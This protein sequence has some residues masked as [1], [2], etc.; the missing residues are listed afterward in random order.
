MLLV[1]IY[2]FQTLHAAHITTVQDQE[3]LSQFDEKFVEIK[4]KAYASDESVDNKDQ[5][6]VQKPAVTDSPLESVSSSLER[7]E[8]SPVPEELTVD[9]MKI[10]LGPSPSDFL[11]EQDET[12]DATEEKVKV[13]H[14]MF[15]QESKDS[16]FDDDKGDEIKIGQLR[17]F[18]RVVSKESSSEHKSTKISTSVE[19]KTISKEYVDGEEPKIVMEEKVF[20]TEDTDSYSKSSDSKNELTLTT[21]ETIKEDF[22]LQADGTEIKRESKELVATI[23]EDSQNSTDETS[24]KSLKKSEEVKETIYPFKK[25]VDGEKKDQLVDTIILKEETLETVLHTHT[26]E[27][28]HKIDETHL[29][30]ERLLEGDDEKIIAGSEKYTGE[31]RQTITEN[32]NENVE[33]TEKQIKEKDITESLFEIRYEP[34]EMPIIE[35]V[36]ERHEHQS[37]E[38]ADTKIFQSDVSVTETVTFSIDKNEKEGQEIEKEKVEKHDRSQRDSGLFEEP[39]SD[40]S[41]SDEPQNAEQLET[42]AFDNMAF[43]DE[44]IVRPKEISKS[45][46]YMADI[47]LEK[48]GDISPEDL[49]ERLTR[50]DFAEELK[51]EM[52]SSDIYQRDDDKTLSLSGTDYIDKK[53]QLIATP[54]EVD[55]IPIDETDRYIASGTMSSTAVGPELQGAVG[56]AVLANVPENQQDLQ[57]LESSSSDSSDEGQVFDKVSGKYVHWEIQHQYS[58]QFS[59]SYSDQGNKELGKSDSSKSLDMGEFYR[60]PESESSAEKKDS[61]LQESENG[62][63]AEI[64]PSTKKKGQ[65][66][67][68]SLS[69]DHTEYFDRDFE[70]PIH[71][72]DIKMTEEWEKVGD[73]KCSSE[74]E[75][76]EPHDKITEAYQQAV[77]ASII[78]SRIQ[79]DQERQKYLKELEAISKETRD[80]DMYS[81]SSISSTEIEFQDEDVEEEEFEEDEELNI[82]V[83]TVSQAVQTHDSQPLSVVSRESRLAHEELLK[84]T[85]DEKDRSIS[86]SIDSEELSTTYESQ[87]ELQEELDV[88][89]LSRK[90]P[91]TVQVQGKPLTETQ[92]KDKEIVDDERL[93]PIDENGDDIEGGESKSDKRVTFQTDPQHLCSVS[94]E[95]L[96]KTS[97]SSSEIEP[98]LLAASYD[99]ESGR[100][101]HVVTTYDLSPD[102]VEKQFL[103]VVQPPKT[104]LSSP[105]DDVFEADLTLGDNNDTVIEQTP[106]DGDVE[107]LPKD[108]YDDNGV[109]PQSLDTA[110]A[111]T[112]ALPS[113][114]APSPFETSHIEDHA[115]SDL[116][117]AA[118]KMKELKGQDSTDKPESEL[119]LDLKSEEIQEVKETESTGSASPFEI[120]SPSDLEGYQDYVEKQVEFEEKMF[121]SSTS[122]ASASSYAEV[123]VEDYE[124][125]K[126]TDVPAMLSPDK[127]ANE[128]SFEHSSLVSSETSEKSIGSS[129]EMPQVENICASQQLD[130]PMQF[131]SQVFIE[132]E[133]LPNGPTEVDY[134]PEIDLDFP[135]QDSQVEEICEPVDAIVPDTSVSTFQTSQMTGSQVTPVSSHV[136]VSSSTPQTGM[137]ES[138]IEELPPQSN[139]DVLIVSDQTLYGLEMPSDEAASMTTSHVECE[140]LNVSGYTS[141]SVQDD[142]SAQ[143]DSR[144]VFSQTVGLD[145]TDEDLSERPSESLQDLPTSPV[146]EESHDTIGA[147]TLM[148]QEA[149]AIVETSKTADQYTEKAQEE[150]KEE[151]YVL[152]VEQGPTS[153]DQEK[154]YSYKDFQT[155]DEDIGKENTEIVPEQEKVPS[156][157]KGYEV[158]LQEIDD[159]DLERRTPETF[160][161]DEPDDELMELKETPDNDIDSKTEESERE[162]I[163]STEER[164]QFEL[165]ADSCDLDRPLTPT[166]VD[167]NQGF[168]EETFTPDEARRLDETVA[169][170][171]ELEMQQIETK[172]RLLEKT[173]CDFVENVL[174]EVKVKVRFKTA[175]DIDDDVALVQSPLSENGGDMTDFADDLPFDEAEEL[176]E[177]NSEKDENTE[178]TDSVTPQKKDFEE[179]GLLEQNNILFYQSNKSEEQLYA[180]SAGTVE[181]RYHPPKKDLVDSGKICRP[182]EADIDDEPEINKSETDGLTC[183]NISQVNDS[184]EFKHSLQGASSD[185]LIQTSSSSERTTEVTSSVLS[186]VTTRTEVQT[187][188]TSSELHT[189]SVSDR[190]LGK[191]SDS[192]SFSVCS[193]IGETGQWFSISK[194]SSEQ[195]SEQELKSERTV[196]STTIAMPSERVSEFQPDNRSTLKF[197]KVTSVSTSIPIRK[198]LSVGSADSLDDEKSTEG[199]KSSEIEDLGDT[200]SVDSFTTVVAAD[201]EEKDDDEDRMADFASLTSSVHSDI[202]G[203]GVGDDDDNLNE[204]DPLEE[205]MAWAKDKK[206]KDSFQISEDIEEE[207]ILEDKDRDEEM[208]PWNKDSANVIGIMPHPWRKDEED[209]DSVGGSDRYDYVD[210][211]ALSVITELSD[212][213]RFEIINKEEIE[214]ESTGS[215]TGTGSDS[216]HYSSPDFPPPS[217]MSNLKFFNKSAERDDISVSSS[218]LEFERLER[219]I[220]QSRSSGSIENGSKDSFG[221]SLDETKFLSKSLEKDDVSISSSLADFERLEREVAQ[222]SS[223]S[224]IEKIFSPAIVSPPETGKSSE[225]SS[226]SGSMTSLA[227]FERLEKEMIGDESR[228]STCSIESSFSHVS[229]TSITSS[230]ASLNEFERLEQEFTIAE[231][232]EKE[233]QKIVSILEAGS[234][235]PNQYTSEPELSHS[236]S[237]A[238]TL[239]IKVTKPSKDDDMDKDSVEGREDIDED[240][241]SENKKKTRGDA[242]DDTDSLDGDRSEMTSS[243]TSAILK[244]ESATKIGTDYDIDSLHDSTHSSDGAMKI[245]SDSLGEKLGMSKPE[246]DKFDTDSLTD[247]EGVIEKS[248]EANQAAMEKSSDSLELK[249]SVM[250]KS[251]DSLELSDKDQEKVETDSLQ[252]AEDAM[253]A[254]VDSLESYQIVAKHN[255]MEVS[256]DSAGTGGWSSASSMF[257]RSSIDTMRSADKEE[258]VETG[259]GQ[260]PDEMAASMESW[261]EYEGEEETDNFYIISKY[262]SSLKEAAEMS[263]G[264]KTE[265][266]EYTH[267]YY[268]FEGNVAADNIQ[269]MMT[270]PDWDTSFGRSDS[271]KSPYLAKTPYEEKKKIYTMTEWEAMKKAKKLQMEEEER[272]KEH[273]EKLEQEETATSPTEHAEMS[274]STSDEQSDK[275]TSIIE[276]KKKETEVPM[277]LSTDSINVMEKTLTSSH[278]EEETDSIGSKTFSET[279]TCDSRTAYSKTSSSRIEM[280]KTQTT[281]TK[282]K[283]DSKTMK[284]ISFVV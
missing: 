139:Q 235:L 216:R 49:K 59:D 15:T 260:I 229:I 146:T 138:V 284:G 239:E 75:T 81:S 262:Q 184:S 133:K 267:P 5:I 171:R 85:F 153:E 121:Q 275:S 111:G 54:L 264:S 106:T 150:L 69:E 155:V 77:I 204:K 72:Y 269:Y 27:G 113:P 187:T 254:S 68:F 240:S 78:E 119:S 159:M 62:A 276:E 65:R 127:S 169:L 270:G 179:S 183:S 182:E 57:D 86:P 253:Q 28:K 31:H 90:Y 194:M 232:L 35:P 55:D 166:P 122:Q 214:S 71:S 123:C 16:L 89:A 246:N 132:D 191:S 112:S 223:D 4:E 101:S 79:T 109:Q 217:P 242:V 241:L 125:E 174:E 157:L 92:D 82:N 163:S 198:S 46:T 98:T 76:A 105:E 30:S 66:V 91:V 96:V 228:K 154:S 212:E 213:D 141:T 38:M 43:N 274:E 131:A 143:V 176:P 249:E 202:M 21:T 265:K 190:F 162:A 39:F 108:S 280:T 210:R 164:G 17:Q 219:E 61:V 230:Q 32:L 221:G 84:E 247:Q 74:S 243:I 114:P 100:V 135:G 23:N 33:A 25:D 73:E 152:K 224:S 22:E 200:S 107:L 87:I 83:T 185:V 233:A 95:D 88:S 209:S 250:E 11:F 102:A 225:K 118:I 170:S 64:S 203:G 63:D 158:T 283:S 238:T 236:E 231:E 124:Q 116:A 165:K 173:A 50:F 2:S 222:G 257:S 56:P 268:D 137:T 14:G 255:V 126:S 26:D 234:L 218:L 140:S 29:S 52:E 53:D 142:T 128:S 12:E 206:V 149:D 42:M 178:I 195:V 147:E 24:A 193:D 196:K 48:E 237:L 129:F 167:K 3:K 47:E 272:E 93:S 251:T 20:S 279:K 104:I 58:R 277:E 7:E 168:F 252:G 94:S 201:E 60:R 8:I 80:S 148:E 110:S 99:L 120:M 248:Q 188:V 97:T 136:T 215:G 45:V 256:M 197:E 273:K 186:S 130:E 266:S 278:I 145:R 172:N 258:H 226:V 282:V 6:E 211:T 117:S 41:D 103:P 67:R 189:V 220:N 40:G 208:F 51:E 18:E 34:G 156:S 151:D 144:E 134:N 9:K 13:N 37:Q 1:L 207:E 199:A 44:E 115:A 181:E 36:Q 245:S 180:T 271:D 259:Q 192:S 160:L 175:L 205:L 281:E 177:D 19:Q 70:E 10:S 244:S 227:E 161:D 263:K 261:E